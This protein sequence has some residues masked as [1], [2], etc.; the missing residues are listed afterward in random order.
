ME[1]KILKFHRISIVFLFLLIMTMGVVC[2][3]DTNQTVSDTLELNDAQDVI[4]DASEK[5]YDDLSKDIN[6][7]DDSITLESDYK[8]KNT[9]SIKHIEFKKR[10][11]TID[12]NNHA[13]DADGKT[14]IFNVNGGTLTLKNLVFKNTNDS[15]IQIKNGILNTINVTF[16]NANSQDYGGAVYA[17]NSYYSSTCDKFSDNSAKDAGSALFASSSKID[18]KNATFTNKNPIEWSLIYGSNCE[19]NVS[20]TTFA[21][22][23]SKYATAIY[24]TY[25]TKITK[26]K[27]INLSAIA[28]GGAVALKAENQKQNSQL[29]I[30]ECEFTNVSAGR[31]GGAVFA[32]IAADSDTTGKG[33]VIIVNTLFNKNTA[34]FGGTLVQLGGTLNVYN[35]LFTNNNAFEN[36]G[37]IF[38]S[39]TTVNIDNSTFTNH[40]AHEIDGYGG[41]VYLDYEIAVI[42]NST[43]TDNVAGKGSAIYS[44]FTL[45]TINNIQFK[46][47][48]IYTRFD[49]DGCSITNCGEYTGTINDRQINYVIRY[50]GDEI[51]LNP[52]N[53]TGTAKDPY[54]NLNDLGLVTP[55][56]NQGSMGSCWAF[57]AAGAFE[58]SYLIATGIELDISENNIQNLCLPYSEYGQTKTTESGNMLMSSAYFTSWLGA[59]NTTADFYDELGKVSALHYGPNAVHT[60]NAVF[61]KIQNKNAIKE[62]LTKYGAMNLF[63]YGA[64]SQDPSY[65]STYKSVYNNKYWGNHYVTLVG[66]DDNFSKN[67]FTTKAPGNGAWICKNSW[68]SEW[69]DGG[70]FYISYYDKSLTAD[71]VGFTFDNVEHYETLYQNE[72]IGRYSYLDKYDAYTQKYTSENGD[73]IAAVG[74]YFET[75]G[76]P[77]T[78]SIYVNDHIAYSQSGKS[79]HAGY[80]TVKLNKYIAVDSN[81][82]F[83]IRI[84]SKSVPISKTTRSICVPGVN[85][86]IIDDEKI[87]LTSE[88][89][90]APVKVYTYHNSNITRNIA[91]YYDNLNE[92]IFTVYNIF[93]GSI[94]ASF[95]NTNYS[96]QIINNTGSISLG[97]LPAGEYLVTTTYKNQTFS[98]PVWI[99]TTIFSNDQTS[100]T[101]AYNAGGSFTVQFLDSNG[102]PLTNTKVSAKFDNK[103]LSNTLTDEKGLLTIDINPKNPIGKH[104]IDYE[105]PKN[106]DRLRITLNVVSRFAENSNINMY[107]YDGHTYAVHIKGNNGKFV[108]ENQIVTIKIGKKSFKVKT[109]MFG[110]AILKIPSKITPGKYTISAT[111]KGQTVKNKLKVKQVLKTKKTVK[112]KKSAKKLLLK[113]SLKKG[114]KA[115][116]SKVIKFKI[117][118]KTYKTKTNKK[119]IAKVTLK[120]AA[121]KKLKA[122]KKYTIKVS[123]LSDVV[124]ATLKVRR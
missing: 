36:G 66:W 1:E 102:N 5:S 12:G 109:D 113:A 72:V 100:F 24:N 63:V 28:T 38:T 71:A 50:N 68:G 58:S 69:G 111:Y 40:G 67:K 91:K 88:D 9:D 57:G 61:I 83:E 34:E 103:K 3:E 75:A 18:I 10:H 114:K 107:Y 2:A 48:A 59:I 101:L 52:Q 89:Y 31:N 94:Q 122:G 115:L 8:Y 90:I 121:I 105:N 49:E 110:Y 33:H 119:G 42:S 30:D 20:D 106:G 43:F 77:Y 74:T 51:I 19:I 60:V 124:K 39:R 84:K 35:S 41:A 70:Y 16:I 118:G 26:S 95:N 120:S 64:N 92:T 98:T 32:D 25:I 17:T 117:N 78:I 47:N 93:E 14:T 29:I 104:Y 97:V 82:T 99:K 22:T 7:A 112:V 55:V 6:E 53:I 96:I 73:I 108:D 54:F 45:Y 76:S 21:N 37:A 46:N 11:F 62:Y 81:S 87:D 116:K 13:I 44:Y 15:A 79:T 27:F 65:S 23:T 4:S 56:K 86:A 80:E 85:Y 123:Y